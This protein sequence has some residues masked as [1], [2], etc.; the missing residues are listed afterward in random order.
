M[1]PLIALII[2]YNLIS[3]SFAHCFCDNYVLYEFMICF[4]YF[5]YVNKHIINIIDVTCVS[6]FSEK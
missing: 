3:E 5:E 2:T 1:L 4:L 6:S